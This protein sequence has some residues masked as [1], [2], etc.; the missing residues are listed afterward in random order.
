[1]IQR[2]F[3]YLLLCLFPIFLSAQNWEAFNS[4]KTY[5]YKSDT[6][7]IPD[8]SVHFDS[9]IV[10]GMDSNFVVARR[11]RAGVDTSQRNVAMFCGREITANSNG[12]FN[13]R[14]PVHATLP[15]LAGL[16][17]AFTLDS[18]SG[19]TAVVTRVYQGMVLGQALDSIKVFTTQTLD[20]LVLSKAHGL[21]EWPASLGSG[22]FVLAGIQE[23]HLG[24][25]LP[26]FD[27]LFQYKAGD[28]YYYESDH[29]IQDLVLNRWNYKVKMAVDSSTRGPS[30]LIVYYSGL[31]RSELYLNST[32]INVTAGPINGNFLIA[33]VKDGLERKSHE[34]QLRVPGSLLPYALPLP[35]ATFRNNPSANT[36]PSDWDGLWTTMSYHDVSGARELHYGRTIGA[37]GWMYAGIGGDTCV[38][39]NLD[40]Q[41]AVFRTGKGITHVEW[42]AFEDY[43]NF[44]L[45]GS[46]ID[47]DTSGTIFPDEVLLSAMDGASNDTRL[48]LFPNPSKG[49][50]K[51]RWGKMGKVQLEVIDL[52]GR[53][54]FAVSANGVE[55]DVD[56]HALPAGLYLMRVTDGNAS[57]YKRLVLEK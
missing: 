3:S 8:Q 21:L 50:L 13:F 6:A 1:M 9:T 2:L 5:H 41:R 47:G 26:G 29:Y 55:A 28:V 39:S 7:T 35:W 15:T 52:Q 42:A 12:V 54:C 38:A 51:V 48:E 43:G 49:L 24:D 45:V 20:S 32:S 33:S 57:T 56:L 18:I 34:E 40:Q 30:G 31:L 17:S 37:T 23:D 27:G 22:H 53:V 19:L 4:G 10:V 11:F 25:T 14:N 46:V 36:T 44:D 16:G